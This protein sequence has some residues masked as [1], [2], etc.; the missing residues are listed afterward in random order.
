[1]V[2][3]VAVATAGT[4]APTG[5][6]AAPPTPDRTIPEALPDIV[7]DLSEAIPA[8]AVP[9]DGGWAADGDGAQIATVAPY[10]RNPL[11]ALPLGGSPWGTV[12]VRG[13]VTDG[14]TVALGVVDRENYIGV[15]IRPSPARVEVFSLVA[16]RATTLTSVLL[17]SEPEAVVEF[18][19]SGGLAGVIASGVA[20]PT[21]DLPRGA[22]ATTIGLVGR[23]AASEPGG[24]T[25]SDVD[26]DPRPPLAPPL[27]P[28]ANGVGPAVANQARPPG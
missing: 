26:V 23:G 6:V 20:L 11:L 22:A 3:V 19:L 16:G 4:E 1:M 9:I 18:E 17:V 5:V 21:V 28:P 25:W 2:V 12:T 13:E 14:W 24:A 15:T 8:A 7:I 10:P 27:R